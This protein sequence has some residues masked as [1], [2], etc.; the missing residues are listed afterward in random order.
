MNEMLPETKLDPSDVT[1]AE[2]LR[3]EAEKDYPSSPDIRGCTS[4]TASFILRHVEGMAISPSDIDV[5]VGR[6]PGEYASGPK[7]ALWLLEQ[8]LRME[9]YDPPEHPLEQYLQGYI[10]GDLTYVEY[11]EQFELYCGKVPEESRLLYRKYIE[12]E[13]VPNRILGESTFQP[14]EERGMMTEAEVTD[15]SMPSIL[16]KLN[17]GFMYLETQGSDGPSHAVCIHDMNDTIFVFWP[18][19]DG[20]ILN[21]PLSEELFEQLFRSSPNSSVWKMPAVIET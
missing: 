14:Y 5:A 7:V 2:R 17:G 1:D 12:D 8:G 19:T 9:S 4:A 11:F 10:V 6:L 21:I 13:L 18:R 20:A 3:D 15:F 16:E